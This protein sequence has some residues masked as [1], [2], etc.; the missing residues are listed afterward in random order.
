MGTGTH[1][2]DASYP[3]DS[4]YSSSVSGTIGLT[5]VIKT[6]PT[7][8]VT[9]G[10]SSITT[11]QALTVK[12]AVSGTPTATGS[13]TLS[14]GSYTSAATPLSSGSAQI[15][16]PA[17][18][19]AAGSDTLTGAYSGDGNYSAN[20]GTASVTVT[21]PPPSFTIAG[22]AVSIARGATTGNTSTITVAPA[23]G[24]TGSIA[25]AAAV[26]SSPSGAHYPPTFS[27]GSTS[28]VSITGTTAG[29]ATLTISTTAAS[30]AAMEYPNRRGVPWYA[31]AS[32]TLACVLLLGIPAR[33]RSWRT[34][35]GLVVLLV[36]LAGGVL[37]CGG[38]GGSGGGG[39]G[40]GNSIPGTTSGT[41]VVTVTG[42]AGATNVT[43]AVT[44]TVQ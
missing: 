31:A 1:Q 34:M 30:I 15:V 27:F 17:G 14:S 4:N 44:L 3:G 41:Y 12:V 22:T 16:I 32:G 23:N 2:V 39:G 18:S 33:R 42:T 6:V 37:A 5:A 7:V 26:T 10:S 9:P 24:F 19:L 28:P 38:G 13:V 25:L 43:G 21:V 8:T 29:I 20:T 36:A 40:G 11:S 35:L